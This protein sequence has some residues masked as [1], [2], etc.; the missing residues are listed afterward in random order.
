MTKHT[1][2]CLGDWVVKSPWPRGLCALN[3][4]VCRC[5]TALQVWQRSL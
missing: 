5:P 4:S 2:E 3:I 1:P